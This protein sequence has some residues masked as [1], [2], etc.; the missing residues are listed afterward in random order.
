MYNTSLGGRTMT[1]DILLSIDC[2][3][4][5]QEDYITDAIE[6]FLMQKTTFQIEILIHDDASTDG[7][8]R[9][10]KEY[11]KRFPKMIKPIYQT[12]N[13]FSQG[14]KMQQNNQRRAKGKYIAVCEGDDYWT[15]PYK[16]QKQVDFLEAN[17]TYSLCVHRAHKFSQAYKKV[18]GEVRPSRKSRS[19]SVEETIEGG[20]ELFPTNSMVY[21]RV[22][23]DDMPSCY[24]NAGIGDYPLA[25]HLA[26]KGRVYYIDEPL[27]VYR[28]DVKGT[29][30]EIT[31]ATK[32]R[33]LEQDRKTAELLDQIN[34]HTHFEY[35]A[36]IELIKKK[37]RFYLLIRQQE[38]RKAFQKEYAEI[39]LHVEFFKRMIKKLWKSKVYA[40]EKLFHVTTKSK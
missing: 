28:V 36:S 24:L 18:M 9:I 29:W 13:Q 33:A 15:D 4:Y 30:S 7:T 6:G 8:V 23:A 32:K 34:Q 37:Y 1:N 39:Y 26:L 40:K 20:G 3:T 16:L 38:F 11:E 27:S 2:L 14:I 31:L 21:R 17:R 35:D 12:E 22:L 19:F 25:I 5:N 10:I